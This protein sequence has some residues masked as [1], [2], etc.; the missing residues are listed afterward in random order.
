MLTLSSPAIPKVINHTI[1]SV[2]FLLG[3]IILMYFI[4]NY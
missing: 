4:S 1:L 3:Q 2:R